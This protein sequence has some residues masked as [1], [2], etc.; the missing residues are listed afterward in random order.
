MA[1]NANGKTG[2]SGRNSGGG[3][4]NS[5]VHVKT[6][7]RTG[8]PANGIN[9]GAVSYLGNK[10]GSHAMDK[11]DFTPKPTPYYGKSPVNA[12]ASLGN[13]VALNGAG[14]G[15]RP[16]GGGRILHGKSGTQTQYGKANP[17]VQGG[18][19]FLPGNP[20]SGPAGFGFTGSGKVVKGCA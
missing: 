1:K 7:V 19:P 16:G 20:S 4:I 6:P 17:G 10:L 11:G 12:A 9:P 5:R 3:G 2:A 13:Q 14:S 15:A 18:S 8:K